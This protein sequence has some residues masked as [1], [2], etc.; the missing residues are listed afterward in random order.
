MATSKT[1]ALCDLGLAEPEERQ[2]GADLVRRHNH[3]WDI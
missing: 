2:G 1:G 3:E